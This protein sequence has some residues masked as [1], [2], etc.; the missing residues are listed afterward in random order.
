MPVSLS[1]RHR[2][3]FGGGGGGGAGAG[4]AHFSRLCRIFLFYLGFGPSFAEVVPHAGPRVLPVEV[5]VEGLVLQGDLLPAKPALAARK[6]L[7]GTPQ[8]FV[9]FACLGKSA[10]LFVSPLNTEIFFAHFC[11]ESFPRGPSGTAGWKSSGDTTGILC[12]SSTGRRSVS[13]RSGPWFGPAQ[14]F[15][16]PAIF[17]PQPRFWRRPRL[18]SIFDREIFYQKYSCNVYIAYFSCEQLRSG[19]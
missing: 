18:V 12:G 15:L 3:G 7:A 4:L 8:K 1:H 5:V 16:G 17:S 14:F 19:T 10:F 6:P 13:W 11:G 2:R 9:A